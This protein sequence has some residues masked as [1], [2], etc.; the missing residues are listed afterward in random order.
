MTPEEREEQ[1]READNLFRIPP[2][3]WIIA[4]AFWGA[5]FALIA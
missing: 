2:I 1:A 5:V 4:V 3:A